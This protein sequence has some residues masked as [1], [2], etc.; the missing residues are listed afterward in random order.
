MANS[1][2]SA[3]GKRCALTGLAALVVAVAAGL[4]VEPAHAAA[5][6]RIGPRDAGYYYGANAS[7]AR[8]FCIRKAQAE[9]AHYK[10]RYPGWN[11]RGFFR[12]DDEGGLPWRKSYRCR[13]WVY[14]DGPRA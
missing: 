10:A 8:S 7:F 2:I 6:L 3:R 11:V 9:T 14:G 12:V 13:I 4:A 1:S 5:T